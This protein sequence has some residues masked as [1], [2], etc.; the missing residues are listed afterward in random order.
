MPDSDSDADHSRNQTANESTTVDTDEYVTTVMTSPTRIRAASQTTG[1]P[2]SSPTTQIRKYSAKDDNNIEQFEV[3]G[4][5]RWRCLFCKSDFAW[6]PTKVLLHFVSSSSNDSIRVCLN[7]PARYKVFY[8]KIYSQR[9][10]Q[11]KEKNA[12]LSMR[13]ESMEKC[14]AET[15]KIYERT[16]KRT[17]YSGDTG[18]TPASAI[19]IPERP[20][21]SNKK[22]IQLKLT[23]GEVTY[24]SRLTMAVGNFI[25]SCGLP[26]SI[27]ESPK[28]IHMIRLAKHAGVNYIPPNRKEV[29]GRLLNVSYE[30]L[31][32]AQMENL[33]KQGEL[34]GLSLYGDGATVHKMP[35]LN[36]LASGVF[37]LVAVL[38]IVNA[39]QHLE[40][41]GK[42]DAEYIAAIMEPYIKKLELACP[43]SVDYLSFDGAGNVQLAG[44][45]LAAKYPRIIVTHGTE[46]VVSLFFQDCFKLPLFS[47]LHKLE[48]KIYAIFGTGARH[49]PYAIFKRNCNELYN[50][51]GIGLFRPA[52]TRMA[53]NA[54]ALMRAL[55]LKEA[56]LSTV[57]SAEFKKLNIRAP[58][59]DIIASEKFWDHVTKVTKI[60]MPALFLLR[61]ADRN[62]PAMDQ[63]FY[64]CRKMDTTITTMKAIVETLESDIKASSNTATGTPM[65]YT[66]VAK[67]YLLDSRN[68]PNP[69]T[70]ANRIR[71]LGQR[72]EADVD[73][74]DS[75]DES[76]SEGDIVDDFLGEEDPP[77]A[78]LEPTQGM[79][80]KAFWEKRS[81]H[82]CHDVAIAAWVCSPIEAVMLDVSENIRGVHMD[83]VNRVLDKWIVSETV[84]ISTFSMNILNGKDECTGI[85]Y[86]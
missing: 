16:K 55:R 22:S 53:G 80:V 21:S 19:L 40:T 29:A 61:L 68:R 20:F 2:Q 24:E 43:G 6:N 30:H 65:N 14:N 47:A 11:N 42:K 46:H 70:L 66:S 78:P 41:G 59:V 83:A 37:Q 12:R 69:S 26:F 52:G 15:A 9:Q 27:A 25:H 3:D 73:D 81:K 63:M 82:L 51:R 60:F 31:Q 48:R 13:D 62:I 38:D 4:K 75:D 86:C 85:V 50:C 36:I 1:T 28:F 57:N 32:Q 44:R 74:S 39:T 8:N 7:V 10:Q 34:F 77:N 64:Y 56:L 18:E 5:R 58:L 49:G 23:D 84:R 71:S 76:N 54:I 79:A 35:L 17:K 33:Q 72:D 67:C 45:I